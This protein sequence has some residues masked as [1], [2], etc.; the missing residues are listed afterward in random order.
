MVTKNIAPYEIWGGNPA[1]LIKKRFSD[2]EIKKLLLLKWWNWDLETIKENLSY[3]R[4]LNIT[5]L[6]QK[7]GD[8]L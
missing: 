8:N 3:L 2:E 7:F 4:S 1:R 5:A 6:W